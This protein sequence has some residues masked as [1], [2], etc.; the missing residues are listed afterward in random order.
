MEE[1]ARECIRRYLAH[2][3]FTSP[4]DWTEADEYM[5]ALW[6]LRHDEDD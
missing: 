3:V 6:T 4:Y 1:F 5:L 2:T